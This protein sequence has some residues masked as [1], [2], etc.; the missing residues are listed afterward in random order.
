MLTSN[1]RKLIAERNGGKKKEGR[2]EWK[3]GDYAL[4]QVVKTRLD[5]M[6][7]LVEIFDVLPDKQIKNVISPKQMASMLKVL[8]KLLEISPPFE[9]I[10]D[11]ESNPRVVRYFHV[12]MASR[13]RGLDNAVTGAQVTY[14]A[15][16]DEL[17][18]W[19]EFR[20]VAFFS[21]KQILEKI[22]HDSKRYTR[23]EFND[24]IRPII[25]NRKDVKVTSGGW[26]IGDAR[27]N[28]QEVDPLIDAERKVLST[29]S[30]KLL[31]GKK[32]EPQ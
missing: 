32:E 2:I 23:K 3:T 30:K 26:T 18:Y 27:D 5:S 1:Q 25:K 31:Q 20:Y 6:A 17:D 21:V 7:D 9:V 10:L 24:L 19:K 22:K 4:R 28:Y 8:E 11:E 14:T 16:D 13:L 15:T 12:D 29:K